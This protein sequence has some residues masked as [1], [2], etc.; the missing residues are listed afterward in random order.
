MC[1]WGESADRRCIERLRSAV[2][3]LQPEPVS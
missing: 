1:P 2:G 3:L